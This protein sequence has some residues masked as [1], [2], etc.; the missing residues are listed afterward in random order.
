ML[1]S[2]YRFSLTLGHGDQKSTHPDL[3]A[4]TGFFAGNGV[5]TSANLRDDVWKLRAAVRDVIGEERRRM[6]G[7]KLR[8]AITSDQMKV[9]CF[10]ALG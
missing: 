9:I 5:A 2:H 3:K 10:E 1:A 6:A 4:P 7:A 8:E